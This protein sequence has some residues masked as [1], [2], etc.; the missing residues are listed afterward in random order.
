VTLAGRVVRL[1]PMEA[2][3]VD[4]LWEVARDQELW[5]R[6]GNLWRARED[7]LRYVETALA[8]AARGEALP[9][10]TTLAA[11]GRVVGST[12]LAAYARE[13]R[14]IE[15]GWTFVARELQRTAVNPESKLLLLRHAFETL[16]LRR[17]EL[18][19]DALNVD[20]RRAILRLGAREEGT[21]RAHMV[22]EDGRVRDTVYYSILAEEWPGVRAALEQRLARK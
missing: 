8:W 14:R 21:L 12:R 17:V 3:H 10:V 20:S 2:R 11:G 22:L 19:T 5:R 6:T 16:G 15:I 13:H 1:V 9:F 4:A 18:K 7:A